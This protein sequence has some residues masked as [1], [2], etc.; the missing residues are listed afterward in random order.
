VQQVHWCSGFWR[1]DVK[2]TGFAFAGDIPEALKYAATPPD[3]ISAKHMVKPVVLITLG[4]GKKVLLLQMALIWGEKSFRS[5]VLLFLSSLRRLPKYSPF[6]K[7]RFRF[8]LK[9][10]KL[11]YKGGF[12]FFIFKKN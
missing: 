10:S 9:L 7:F 12:F 2:T 11:Y 6:V 1:C 8:N 5:L 4:K 3:P